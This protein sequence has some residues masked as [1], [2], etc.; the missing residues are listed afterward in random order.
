MI[1]HK[2][3]FQHIPLELPNEIVPQRSCTRSNTNSSTKYQ[4][5]NEI[6]IK[7]KTFSNSFFVRTLSHWNRLPEH[8]RN[9]SEPG[10]FRAHIMEN[11]WSSVKSRINE[12][13][14][15]DVTADMEPDYMDPS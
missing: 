3:V 6:T 4:L 10:K 8:C 2:F 15:D 12:L 11:F 14:Q 1:F 7:N 5:V 9:I 13:N